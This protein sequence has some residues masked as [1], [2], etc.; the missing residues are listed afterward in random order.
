MVRCDE[1]HMVRCD[2]VHM[3]RCDAYG[4]MQFLFVQQKSVGLQTDAM[5]CIWSDVMHMVRCS[6]CLYNKN[7]SDYKP[8]R[9]GVYGPI[10][11]GAFAPMLFLF[12]QQKSVGLQTDE[13]KCIW[14]DAVL[15]QKR[16]VG[17]QTDAMRCIWSDA[18]HMVR[19][20]A[21]YMQCPC[22]KTFPRNT[23]AG[24]VKDL[25]TFHAYWAVCFLRYLACP[26]RRGYF[27]KNVFSHM[28][29]CCS[30]LYKKDQ[31]D[32]KP[33]RCIWS[34][35]V[36]VCTKKIANRCDAAWR[37]ARCIWSDAMHMVRCC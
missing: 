6:S 30:C 21:V 16:S 24:L 28:H 3:V 17:L 32:Y 25:T 13:M 7:Q 31:S 20:D 10:R 26:I 15:V 33:I 14:S 8:M 1:V 2:A 36:L 18:E 35:V 27:S 4:L 22:G 9:C 11:C 12:V 19:C 34:D 23:H 37:P 5:W 29:R